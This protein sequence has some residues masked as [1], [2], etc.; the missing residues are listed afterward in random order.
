M[1]L[2]GK[3]KEGPKVPDPLETM[4]E[5]DE[6]LEIIDKKNALLETRIKN[7]EQEALKRM[8]KNDKKGN[9]DNYKLSATISF[10][11]L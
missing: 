4:M 6:Q 2:F 7:A 8:K 3:K 11:I 5:L 9:F 1:N 10:S